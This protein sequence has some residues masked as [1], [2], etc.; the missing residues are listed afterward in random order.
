MFYLQL[1]IP[2]LSDGTDNEFQ[3]LKKQ[4][5]DIRLRKIQFNYFAI[6]A[7]LT[8]GTPQGVIKIEPNYTVDHE[9]IPIK[10]ENRIII[11]CAKKTAISQKTSIVFAWMVQ[12]IF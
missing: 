9:I 7:E 12:P 10:R 6:D 8:E 4:Y 2:N 11:L 1:D 3:Q 5:P